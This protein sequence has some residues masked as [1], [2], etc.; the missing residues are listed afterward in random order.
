MI[1]NRNLQQKFKNLNFGLKQNNWWPIFTLSF[2]SSEVPVLCCSV[3]NVFWNFIENTLENTRNFIK[4]GLQHG[5]TENL[6]KAAAFS[7]RT[8][9]PTT[10]NKNY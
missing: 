10:K 1:H 7:T 6:L 5:R 4:T 8:E 2:L 3:D 9:L